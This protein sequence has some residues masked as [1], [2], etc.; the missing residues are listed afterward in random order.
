MAIET[1]VISAIETSH[2]KLTFVSSS[3]DFWPVILSTFESLN[4]KQNSGL[5]YP[6]VMGKEGVVNGKEGTERRDGK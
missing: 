3:F 5:Q 1:L 2:H 4:F 6:P